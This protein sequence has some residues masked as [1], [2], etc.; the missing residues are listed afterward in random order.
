MQAIPHA[1]ARSAFWPYGGSRLPNNIAYQG[2]LAPRR[3]APAWRNLHDEAAGSQRPRRSDRPG[4]RPAAGARAAVARALTGLVEHPGAN[5]LVPAAI[6]RRAP[7]RHPPDALVVRPRR[8][9]RACAARDGRA[10]APPS[11]PFATASSGLSARCSHSSP[12]VEA[13]LR[14]YYSRFPKEI[15]EGNWPGDELPATRKPA[16]LQTGAHRGRGRGD[17]PGKPA[18]PGPGYDP[19]GLGLTGGKRAPFT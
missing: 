14:L 11:T 8:R 7:T 5:A 1:F 4:A 15:Q 16:G 10:S 17:P 3:A 9:G 2:T 13:K 18:Q 12:F 19:R 6:Q